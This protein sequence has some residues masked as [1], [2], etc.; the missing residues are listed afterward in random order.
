MHAETL[1]APTSYRIVTPMSSSSSAS[2]ASSL[3]RLAPTAGRGIPYASLFDHIMLLLLLLL[4]ETTFRLQQVER[5]FR[6]QR[7]VSSAQRVQVGCAG[8]KPGMPDWLLY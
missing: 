6:L 1:C 5:C 2:R 4:P 3:S 8:D 7:P